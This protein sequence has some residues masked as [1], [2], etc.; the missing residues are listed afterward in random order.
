LYHVLGAFAVFQKALTA[1]CLFLAACSANR[2]AVDKAA[3][4]REL[5]RVGDEAAA[6]L[7][8]LFNRGACQSIYD[9]VPLLPASRLPDWNAQCH[10][11]HRKLG[12]WSSVEAVSVSDCASGGRLVCVEGTAVFANGVRHSE[13]IWWVDEGKPRLLQWSLAGEGEVIQLPANPR[14]AT[15]PP[16]L[17]PPRSPSP[18]VVS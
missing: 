12:E 15:D 8:A 5:R 1:C 9:Q 13:M 7:R 3:M 16:P 2:V 6:K 14:P 17:A 18:P 4:T 10:D 11:A